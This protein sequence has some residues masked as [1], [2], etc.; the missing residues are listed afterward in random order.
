MA[1]SSPRVIAI[2]AEAAEGET[3][4]LYEQRKKIYPRSVS[5]R[6][7]RWRWLAVWL[8]QCVFYGLPWLSWND[9]DRKS[10]V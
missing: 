8:T 5:G 10:V 1:S 2:A 7:A 4:W 6:F 3:V 9:R